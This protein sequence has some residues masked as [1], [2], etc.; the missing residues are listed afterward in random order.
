[1][2]NG[3]WY[4]GDRLLIPH[5]GNIQEELFCLAHDILAHFRADKL[6]VALR[7]TYYWPNM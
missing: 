2:L 6:Y 7:D 1:M 3:L 5:T 4:I